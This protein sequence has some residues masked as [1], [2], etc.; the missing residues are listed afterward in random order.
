MDW[1]VMW[2]VVF[3]LLVCGTQGK[4]EIWKDKGFHQRNAKL[5][6]L[7][8]PRMMSDKGRAHEVERELPERVCT[9]QGVSGPKGR[10]LGNLKAQGAE[11][12]MKEGEN[13][14]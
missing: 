2:M 14:K 6:G 4:D 13:K 9:K 8:V 5:K 3:C 12:L 11:M 7:W 1:V 10:A